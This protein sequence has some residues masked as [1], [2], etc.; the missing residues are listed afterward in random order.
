MSN[1]QM[2]HSVPTSVSTINQI[3]QIHILQKQSQSLNL[4]V[5]HTEVKYIPTAVH[6]GSSRLTPNGQHL[7]QHINSAH[8][9]CNMEWILHLCRKQNTYQEPFAAGPWRAPHNH[10]QMLNEVQTILWSPAPELA[11]AFC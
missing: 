2:Q 11:Q 4:R 7:S 9:G 5:L 3:M 8:H 10:W 6:H 1:S